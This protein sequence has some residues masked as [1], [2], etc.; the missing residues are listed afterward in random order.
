LVQTR[1]NPDYALEIY[2]GCYLFDFLETSSV[3]A[4]QKDRNR[5]DKRDLTQRI[6]EKFIDF[7]SSRCKTG[8][9]AAAL[10]LFTHYLPK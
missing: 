8:T 5:R 6:A 3:G 4:V 2:T 1:F 7:Q 10:L 9:S